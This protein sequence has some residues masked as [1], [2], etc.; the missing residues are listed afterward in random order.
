[1]FLF[2]FGSII[3]F[4]LSA[5]SVCARFVKCELRFFDFILLHSCNLFR[6]FKPTPIKFSRERITSNN[7]KESNVALCLLNACILFLKTLQISTTRTTRA[8]TQIAWHR[9]KTTKKSHFAFQLFLPILHV[10][11]TLHSVYSIVAIANAC[12][13]YLALFRSVS[14]SNQAFFIR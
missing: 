8:L 3:I 5:K 6:R 10:L 1:M 11:V 14:I 9:T 7:S 4:E 12:F 13:K 2:R